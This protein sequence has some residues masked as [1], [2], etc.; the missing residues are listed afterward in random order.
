[1][2]ALARWIHPTQGMIS[3]FDFI[4][5]AEE[6]GQI[7]ALGHQ[8]LQ[9]VINDLKR[10]QN[11][12][13]SL[14]VAVNVSARQ[15]A[16]KE[17]TNTVINL[18]T[19]EEINPALLEMEVTEQVFLGDIDTARERLKQLHNAG[20]TIALDDFGTGFSSFGYLRELPIDTLKI[21]RSF[22]KNID[23]NPTENAIVRAIVG[24]CNDLNL[25]VVVEGVETSK[26]A[27][28]LVFLGCNI[29]QG[30]H[31]HYPMP[32]DELDKI[33]YPQTVSDNETIN[34]SN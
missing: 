29:A 8:L 25:N 3:P 28:A 18:L 32:A 30:Y 33:L 11:D 14:P 23:S 6:T 31:Y 24:M 10:W 4:S 7:N 19:M 22:I 16:E 9:Q 15:F 13:I 21:D 1:M 20:L 27:A 2:E 34:G 26:Q 12:G 5:V 17:F